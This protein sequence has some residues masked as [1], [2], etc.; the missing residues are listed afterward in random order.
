M[1]HRLGF[2][3]EHLERA[4]DGHWHDG[5][6][7]LVRQHERAALEIAHPAV[8]RAR[9]LRKNHHRHTALQGLT[10]LGHGFLDAA[11]AVVHEYLARHLAG[12][13]HKRNLTKVFFHHPFEIMTHI[14]VGQ[15]YVE[16]ALVVRQKH[17]RLLFLQP[18]APFHLD[19]KQKH[20]AREF[21][22]QFRHEVVGL[23][24][25][26]KQCGCHNH[27]GRDYRDHYKQRQRNAE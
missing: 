22:P 15:E 7:Y 11:A 1:A 21:R 27:Q 16:I 8:V 2:P 9:S 3:A 13:A 14:A 23:V 5:Q 6:P 24:L 19:A 10:R 18:L 25:V 17:I 26:A 12:Y 4:V 20:A